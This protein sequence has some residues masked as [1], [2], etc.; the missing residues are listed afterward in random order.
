MGWQFASSCR[1]ECN[2]EGFG[3]HITCGIWSRG[4]AALTAI[5][6]SPSAAFAISRQSV[7]SGLVAFPL[8]SDSYGL[9]QVAVILLPFWLL[10]VSFE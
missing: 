10:A 6:S 1:R 3:G 2:A 7:L 9:A 4:R 8:P 5:K